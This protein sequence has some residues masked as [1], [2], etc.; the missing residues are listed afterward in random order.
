MST[1]AHP[2]TD[3]QTEL[4]NRVLEDVLRS[5]ATSFPSWSSFLPMAKFALNNATHASTGLTP[6]FVNNARHPRVPALLAVRSFNPPAV[7]TLGGGGRAPTPQSVQSSSDPPSDEPHQ[8]TASEAHVVEGHSLHGVAYEELTAVDAAM[9][10]ASTVTNFAPKPTP[11]PIDSATVSELLLHRQAVSRYVRDALQA[12]ADQQKANVDRRGRKNMLSIRRGDRVLLST[13]GIQG[14]AVTNLGANKL[15][16]HFIGPFKILKV[17][18]DAY[19]LD[20]PTSMRLHPTFYVG[21]LKPYVPATIPALAAD[22]LQPARP[23]SPR[24]QSPHPQPARPQPARSLSVPTDDVDAASARA[25]APHARAWPSE[26]PRRQDSPDHEATP[27]SHVVPA[28]TGPRRLQRPR[29]AGAQTRRGS[30]LPSRH[31]SLG[32][33]PLSLADIARALAAPRHQPARSQ[34][35]SGAPRQR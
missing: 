29:H 15:A 3:G 18:G 6:F 5:Y 21:R 19:T 10:A 12:A 24:P 30:E 25:L 17:I 7:S 20:I 2:E 26:V 1:A 31:P 9:P 11:T 14:S 34:A 13:D 28:P 22:R 23:Q 4:V 32:P 33:S 8:E 27:S 16:P 35:A